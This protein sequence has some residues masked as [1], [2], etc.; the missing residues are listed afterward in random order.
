[1]LK[2]LIIDRKYR[3]PRTWSNTELKKFAHLF[4]GDVVNISGWKDLDKE[5]GHYKDYFTKADNY[6]I[7][8]YR[9]EARGLQGFDNE[10]YLDLTEDLEE[11]YKKR[12]DVAFNHTTLEH[13]YDV[14]KSFRNLC[15][16]SR[17]IVVIVVP[18]IQQ[19]HSTYGDYWRFTPMA[20]KRLFEENGMEM[21]YL[22]FNSHR[23]A[24]VYIFAIASWKPDQWRRLIRNDFNYR[25]KADIL[26]TGEDF[27]GSRAIINSWPFR[28][29]RKIF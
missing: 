25:C 1:M 10:F 6:S 20:V 4:T 3:L 14:R 12:F 13:I 28:I 27:I 2:H 9:S 29:L 17:D 18:F 16:M 19:M 15:I 26:D 23:H 5:G 21:L 11:Q 8:N 24:S 22:S 7:S